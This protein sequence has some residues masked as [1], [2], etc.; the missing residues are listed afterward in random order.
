MMKDR[1]AFSPLGQ[2][3]LCC[4]FSLLL[5]TSF[6]A[7][8]LAA[9]AQYAFRVA[10][11]D[12]A[13]APQLSAAP[14]WLS[15]RALA[16]RAAFGIALDSTDRPVSP[17]YV[18]TVLALTGGKLHNTSRWLNQ[19]VVLLTDSTK[20]LTLAGKPWI[21]SITWVG[22]FATG[23]H[24]AGAT[25]TNPKFAA[26][27]IR[28]AKQPFLSSARTAGSATYYGTTW[29][30]TNMVHGDTLHDQGYR[31][32]G[33][34]IAVLDDGFL[35]VDSHNGFDSLMHS[36]RLIET[37]DFVH[38]SSYVFAYGSHGTECLSVIAGLLPGTFV[39]TAPDA[40]YALYVTE[41]A[42][43]TDALYELDNLVSGMERADSIGADVISSSLVYNI[44]TNPYF[45]IV[46][47]AALDGHTMP[48]ARAM[49][50]ATAKGIL[51]VEAAGNEGAN[52]WNFLTT[53]AD[54]DS[55]LTIGAVTSARSPAGFSSPGPNAAGRIKPDVCLQGDP[56]AVFT[57]G[58]SVGYSGGTSFSCPQAAGWAACLLQA[59]P[60][61]PPA[62]IRTAI[63]S[64][65][66][67]RPPTPKLGFGI[68]DFRKAQ[69]L[70]AKFMTPPADGTLRVMPNPF[71]RDFSVMLPNAAAV[72]DL[73]LYDA[74]GR[75]VSLVQVRNGA[76]IKAS[77]ANTLPAG[78]YVL[79]LVV[80]GQQLTQKLVHY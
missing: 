63:D 25:S 30:Q 80:E 32:R 64:S 60:A 17:R 38:D 9:P 48:V 45:Y 11:K 67:Q 79:R 71:I 34:L 69:Q 50:I 61:L 59:F 47:K 23:L 6:S 18:D 72:A 19:C 22:F 66:D 42:A 41:D 74:L 62:I 13:G 57:S 73:R 10:F 16:R 58:N 33:K 40:Q 21:S 7:T 28:D 39:G 77:V 53:P 46:D 76:S 26:E 52:S 15:S 31:G 55:A 4:C 29:P 75:E 35:E 43:I 2:F 5:I 70:L 3:F 54:A 14:S 36:G 24:R 8:G 65:A 44:F 78:I 1:S 49:N 12:K 68:P 20:I 51:C 37:H 56:A 27:A